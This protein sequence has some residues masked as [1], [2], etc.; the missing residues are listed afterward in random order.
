MAT[1]G[2]TNFNLTRNEI[3]EHALGLL[4]VYGV[5]NT[6]RAED[7]ALANVSLNL[8]IKTWQAQGIHLWTQEKGILFIDKYQS[9]YTLGNE[10]THAK[11]CALDDAVITQIAT[12]ASSGATTLVVDDTTGMAASDNIGIAQDDDTMLW[13]TIV[14]VDSSTGLTI[15]AA[16]TDDVAVN[17]NVYTFTSRINKPLRIQNM[18]QITGVKSN[19]TTTSEI[20]MIELSEDDYESLASPYTNGK[21]SHWYYSPDISTGK[22]YLWPRPNNPQNYFRFTYSRMIEDFDTANDNADFPTEWLEPI[23]WSLAGR[24]GPHFGKGEKARADIIPYA[25]ILLNNLL[26][27]DT[28]VTSITFSPGR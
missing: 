17:R 11:A 16:L 20:P 8:M 21:S 14:S 15:T 4:E 7:M 9:T 10:S 3:I 22:L 28:E 2:S 18:K 13:T 1:S 26:T 19:T 25:S 6:I 5:G 24:L 23:I 27:Y 12:A